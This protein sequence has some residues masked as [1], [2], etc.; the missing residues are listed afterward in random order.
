MRNLSI[1]LLLTMSASCGGPLSM[2]P[3]GELSGDVKSAP[4][5]WAT[6]PDTIQVETRPSD[7]YSINIWSVGLDEHLYIATGADGTTWTEFFATD[8]N[9][10]VRIIDSLYELKADLVSS[11]DERDTVSSAY[12]EKYELDPEDN[13]L[14]TGMIFRLDRR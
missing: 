3:G 12:V 7:P 9:V 2:I 6:V 14:Q 1:T 5:T 13:W 11:S 8:A 10:R 4:L